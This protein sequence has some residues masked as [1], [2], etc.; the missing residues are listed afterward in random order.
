MNQLITRY[1]KNIGPNKVLQEYPRPQLKRD[2][3]INLNG[4]WDF[5]ISDKEICDKYDER[6]LVPFSPESI[7][8]G[9]N[10]TLLPGMYAHYRKEIILNSD[11]IKD[12]VI[13]HFGAVD[14]IT[15][16]YINNNFVLKHVGGYVPFSVDITDYIDDSLKLEIRLKVSDTT[17]TSYHLYGKQRLVHEGIFYTPQSGIW[18]TVWM[19]SVKKDYFKDISIYP[20]FD[21][22]MIYIKLETDFLG[23]YEIRVFD[24]DNNLVK[25][26]STNDLINLIKLDGFTPWTPENPYL[27][28]LEIE[29]ESDSIK[30]YVGMRIFERKLDD[31]GIMR[32]YL[33]HKP[34]FQSGVL[35]Q[36]YFSD[37]LLTA[38]SDQAMIDD[39]LVM[40]KLGFN[41]LRKHIK[42]EP[43]RWYYHCDRLG[44]LVWQDMLSGC[45]HKNVVFHHVLS[46]FH[47]HLNDRFKRL[48]GRNSAEG[49]K[50]YEKDLEIM[51]NYL[52]NVTSLCVWVP[53]N[54]AWGQFDTLRI[55]EKVRTYDKHRLIDHASG[56]S[57]HG[58]GDFYSRH[59]Y[60]Q[61]IKFKKRLA[62]KR[63]AAL[64]EFGGFSYPVEGH[65]YN[66]EIIFGYKTFDDL[67]KFQK[68]IEVLYKDKIFS[69]LNKGLSVLVYTQ[70]SDVEDEVNGFLTYD[71]EVLKVDESMV[72][73][74]NDFIY[75]SFKKIVTQ[76]K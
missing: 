46:I 16:L 10:K 41:M 73:A 66:D 70:L 43:L 29:S 64:T 24:N 32:F 2:S 74:L 63:I 22:S 15:D 55:L 72:K 48:F 17:D 5:S 71:R 59:I 56:W 39:I 37:G 50:L 58:G 40:K 36:G 57:D 4:Y 11:F 9:V 26:R 21:E 23:E 13:L 1:G 52:K 44:M 12:L 65:R 25:K 54:E 34:Y 62:K 30:T 38:P 20:L 68:A 18:Q 14:Q 27:Y 28:Y 67:S 19:E 60:Y 75:D 47:I 45:E 6:I 69:N 61:G 53:F 7:L 31:S 33:N 49:K 42:I 8:S 35:D 3:Y 51:L 76:K